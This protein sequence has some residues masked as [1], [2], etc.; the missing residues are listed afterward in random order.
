MVDIE[1]TT[2]VKGRFVKSPQNVQYAKKHDFSAMQ[3]PYPVDTGRKLNVHKTFKRRPGRSILVLCLRGIGSKVSY[4]RKN[5]L[6]S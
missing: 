5:T 4:C 6:Q 2:R 3:R 1:T